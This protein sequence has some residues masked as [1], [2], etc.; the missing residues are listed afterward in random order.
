[1]RRLWGEAGAAPATLTV[2]EGMY[3]NRILDAGFNP[4][5]AGNSSLLDPFPV[6]QEPAREGR[7]IESGAS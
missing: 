1:M 5:M 2:S 3:K 6:S 4:G 7:V